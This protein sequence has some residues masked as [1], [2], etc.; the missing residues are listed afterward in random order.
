VVGQGPGQFFTSTPDRLFVEASDLGKEE[1]TAMADA[2]GLKG[3][4]PA[5]LLFV[6]AAEQQIDL[7]M[8]C[9]FGVLASLA[10]RRTLTQE[11]IQ[12]C[13]SRLLNEAR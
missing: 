3:D 12:R 4:I 10:T 7:L 5:A 1:V 13:H 8:V 2:V 11:N 9:P 6:Q